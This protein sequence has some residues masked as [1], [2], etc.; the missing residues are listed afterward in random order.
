MC[1]WKKPTFQ[2]FQN[3]EGLYFKYICE[4]FMCFLMLVWHRSGDPSLPVSEMVSCK[5]HCMPVNRESSAMPC[6]CLY[7]CTLGV[8]LAWRP[9]PCHRGFVQDEWALNPPSPM[10]ENS[11]AGWPRHSD[12][13]YLWLLSF[14]RFL[15]GTGTDEESDVSSPIVINHPLLIQTWRKDP[16][17][18]QGKGWFCFLSGGGE[19]KNEHLTLSH[20]VR[21]KDHWGLWMR[22]DKKFSAQMLRPSTKKVQKMACLTVQFYCASQTRAEKW[23]VNCNNVKGM[24]LALSAIH[25]MCWKSDFGFHWCGLI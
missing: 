12:I 8:F 18:T 22:S 23:K 24:S 1:T 9:K 7:T 14:P 11:Y 3:S 20:Q 13:L 6:V 16:Y 2:R 10:L 15:T 19:K 21:F 25:Y 4:K 5:A 17:S